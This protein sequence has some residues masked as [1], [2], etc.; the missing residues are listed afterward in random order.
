MWAQQRAERLL[1]GEEDNDHGHPEEYGENVFYASSKELAED[2][3]GVPGR[4]SEST[5]GA[6]IAQRW[7]DEI[8]DY[9]GEFSEETAHFTQVVWQDSFFVGIEKRSVKLLQSA[10]KEII[11]A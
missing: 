4:L 7:Y 10:D 9:C 8:E 3:D 5:S 2:T 6:A 1:A 11:L